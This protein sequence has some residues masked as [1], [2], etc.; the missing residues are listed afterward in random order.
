MEKQVTAQTGKGGYLEALLNS[1]PDAV[2]AI[3]AEGT[4]TFANKEACQL[5][6]CE[7]RDLVGKS[8]VIIYESLEHARETNRKLFLSGGIVHD[9]ESMLKT[10]KGKLIPV[11][12]SASHLKDG[13]GNYAGA[14]GYFQSYRPWPTAE[15]KVKAHVEELEAELEEWKDLGAPVYEL[16]PGMVTIVIVGRL[17]ADRINR[18]KNNLS[19]H[20]ESHKTSVVSI[21]L[22]TALI[23]NAPAV[24]SEL[25]KMIRWVRLLGVETIINGVGSSLAEALEPLVGDVNSLNVFGSR[26]LAHQAA[27]NVIGLEIC[28]KD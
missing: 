28:K 26:D 13:T 21:Y 3:N 6:E 17:D 27:L 12:I 14:V 22:S 10:K 1:C 8:I 9:H 19:N 25:L 18:I 24:A 23:D 20:M 4:M 11:R 16:Y 15:A 5:I 7:M 2:I